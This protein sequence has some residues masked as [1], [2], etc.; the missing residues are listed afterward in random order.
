MLKSLQ[1]QIADR[2][3]EILD[4]KGWKQQHLADKSGLTKAYISKIMS[5][6]LNLTLDT[7]ATL[8]KALGEKIMNI[9][10]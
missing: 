1:L 5:G 9:R 3:R 2:I 8:E 7:I 6:S 4:K 10:K